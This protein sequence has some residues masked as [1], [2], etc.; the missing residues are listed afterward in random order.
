[1][2][3]LTQKGFFVLNCTVDTLK[4]KTKLF[5]EKYDLFHHI[6]ESFAATYASKMKLY[7]KIKE[8]HRTKQY[9]DCRCSN[10]S[11]LLIDK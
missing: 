10:C 4:N 11:V 2:S 7:H 1:M 9:L 3:E 5:F 6:A 8:K